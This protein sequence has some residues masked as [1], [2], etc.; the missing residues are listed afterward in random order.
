MTEGKIYSGLREKEQTEEYQQI[1]LASM[2]EDI[3]MPQM[4]DEKI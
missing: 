4:P 1:S 2:T 3:V